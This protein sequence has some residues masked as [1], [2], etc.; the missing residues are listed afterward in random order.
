M[1]MIYRTLI[2]A[3]G[4]FL[5]VT[6]G[7]S[8]EDLARERDAV[9]EFRRFFRKFK[10]V[11]QRA[12]AVQTLKG[13]ECPQAADEL[14][15]LLDHKESLIRKAAE[16]VL[17]T[18]SKEKTYSHLIDQLPDMKNQDR[19]ALLIGVFGRSKVRAVV[20]VLCEIVHKDRRASTLVNYEIA[21][22]LGLIGDTDVQDTLSVL[23][24][25][26]DQMVRMAA[27]DAVGHLRIKGL[28]EVVVRLLED[29]AWQ[30]RSAAI[31]TIGIVRPQ[32][33][34]QPLIDLMR[35]KGRLKEEAAETLFLITTLDFGANP[36][37]WQRQWDR[38]KTISWKIPT[39]EDVAKAKETRR[40]N[41]EFYG[42]K[43]DR[44]SFG[45]IATTSTQILF[46]IDVSGSMDD[47]VVE[48]DKFESGHGDLRKLSIV[49]EEL[50]RTIDSLGRSTNFNIV[51]FATHMKPWK[52]FSVS[53]NI[54]NK[55]SAKAWVKR[56]KP[57][58]GSQAQG[59]ASAGLVGAA[60]LEAGKTN[61]H[62]ALMFPFGIDPE[63]PPGVGVKSGKRSAKNKLDTVF[64]LSDGRPSTGR[65]VDTREILKEVAEINQTYRVV[66]HTIAIG[67]FQ[68]DFLRDLATQ[69]G[70]VFVDLGM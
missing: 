38:L 23:L 11:S 32:E 21:Q 47:F 48:T 61:T 53:A 58:G 67:D 52:K 10:E 43:E 15:G 44:T 60:N 64:F 5:V 6:P 8:Q 2:I 22:A 4:A 39:D 54:V 34:V 14:V 33:A 31:K 12:E 7:P 41:D 37:E 35:G 46:I 63:E 62:G 65:L 30:I 68:R 25:S 3:F 66:F 50:L 51:A 19:R 26:K 28:G 40:R 20:P 16:E 42:K 57:I 1:S 55:A 27:V 36:D 59:L 18:Y 45:G 56:L 70:G 17:G 69:N 13:N 9:S 29:S 24:S 49:R